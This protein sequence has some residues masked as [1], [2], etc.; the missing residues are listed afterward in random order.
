VASTRAI[1]VTSTVTPKIQKD[2][3]WRWN[4]QVWRFE[5]EEEG[6]TQLTIPFTLFCAVALALTLASRA[7]FRLGKL[8]N[9]KWM[10]QEAKMRINWE[11]CDASTHEL[12]SP[13]QDHVP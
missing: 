11:T 6:R 2:V 10:G 9:N 7:I 3:N 1:H 4:K 12:L 5:R 13:T 8:N